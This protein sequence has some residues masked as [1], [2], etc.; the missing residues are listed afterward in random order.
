MYAIQLDMY[1]AAAVAALVLLLGRFLVRNLDL[2]R[3]YCI[4]EPVAG[5]VV[6]ALAHLALRQA[7]ILEISFD[8]TLQTFFMVVFFCSVG[9]T[10]C[11]RLLKKGGLQVLLFLGIAVMMCVL[12]NGL[13][14]FIAS[15]FGLDPR[16]GLATGSIPMVGGH[17]TA[18]SF[19]PLL[20]KAGV[21]GASAVAIASATFGLVAGCVIGG[22]TAVSRIRQ[23]NLHSFETATGSNEVVVDK[24]EVTGAIDSG[25]FL[26]AALCL[27][28]AIGAG[29]V[30]SAWLNKVFTFPI[31][32]GAMLVAAFIRNTTDM[33]GKEIP[34]EEISTI[35]SFS[36]S[37]FLGLAMMGL[38]LWELADLAVPMVVMLVAQTV[39]MMVY[40]Y[41]VVFN[42]LGKNYD[43]AVMTSGF[44]GFGMGA[45]P[46]A[47][48]NMQAI[49]QKYGPAPTAYF[50]VPLVGSLFI[51]F[52]NT[53]II[54]SFLNLL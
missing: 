5:G 1:Q 49:T 23:K 15:A 33:A 14:A 18:A 2:L 10:A 51:D 13:G 41:F 3:R 21:S 45:T 22:P 44:C 29:T 48:A 25:R 34:M 7:G 6:F 11:F 17:G 9:F 39:L 53:I 38:K 24:N 47:M 43:A 54:T 40:A 50:V 16:L 37:L 20:E 36:L 28:L 12:Q 8:S 26:N 19:G 46:N 42:L 35:G 30:V 52:M 4:P 27:A 31:Y 32:I